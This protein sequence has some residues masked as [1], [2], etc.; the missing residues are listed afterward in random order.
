M[1]PCLFGYHEIGHSLMTDPNTVHAENPYYE[2]ILQYGQSDMY[3]ATVKEGRE[4]LEKKA[5][6]VG[7]ERLE[8]L[9]DIFA[10]AT[11]METAFWTMGLG[12][13]DKRVDG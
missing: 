3:T 13:S 1:A 5:A 4:L 2:W 11:K 12:G 7:A 10:H 9:V 6:E 8:E